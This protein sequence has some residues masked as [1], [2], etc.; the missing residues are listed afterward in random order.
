VS[1]YTAS[2]PRGAAFDGV[3]GLW[4]ASVRD[5]VAEQYRWD[6]AELVAEV[7]AEER[8]PSTHPVL[9]P[10]SRHGLGRVSLSAEAAL[11]RALFHSAIDPVITDPEGGV[12]CASC[13]DEGRADG[14][15][16]GFPEG[17]RQTPSL[18]GGLFGTGPY[19]WTGNVPTVGEIAERTSI[20][21]MGGAGPDPA[22]RHALE[23]Y[24]ES[25]RAPG[26]PSDPDDGF[27]VLGE[28]L[29]HRDDVG[30]AGCHAPETGTDGGQ[31]VVYG[32]LLADTPHLLGLLATPPYMH[33]GGLQTL[34]EVI[35]HAAT[36]A[37]GDASWL[38][39]D[40]RYALERYLRTR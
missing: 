10:A 18:A 33:D 14:L 40:Q 38:D 12:A 35:D 29:F 31:H 4:V 20:V 34:D 36:G 13:H 25:L 19:G 5:R 15:T 32:D 7:A 3:G 27:E 17:P 11:G 23:L 1:A 28:M 24:I 39:A 30:C 21:R 37:M 26:V 9:T 22:E 2:G 16:W 8:V 6:D